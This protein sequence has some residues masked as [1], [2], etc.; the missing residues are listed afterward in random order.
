M[1]RMRAVVDVRRWGPIYG[2]RLVSQPVG[3]KDPFLV[4]APVGVR[5]EIVPLGLDEV[6][7]QPLGPVP[8]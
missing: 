2:A 3:V 5:T 1:A 7:G 4:D 6:G 8:V